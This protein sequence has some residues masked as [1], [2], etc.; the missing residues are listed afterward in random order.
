[1][2]LQ[3]C[4]VE[5]RRSIALSSQHERRQDMAGCEERQLH[6]A[7]CGGVV[8]SG[9]ASVHGQVAADRRRRAQR[10]Q[11]AQA[12]PCYPTCPPCSSGSPRCGG[13]GIGPRVLLL[14]LGPAVLEPDLDLGL[15]EGQGQGQVE[16]LAHR[17]VACGL[18]FVFQRHQLL[19]GEGSPGPAGLP[20]LGVRAGAFPL[21]LGALPC[22]GLTIAD[23]S[24]GASIGAL[25]VSAGVRVA[26]LSVSVARQSG[27]AL[28]A[29]V[30]P[31]R[32]LRVWS[33]R[34]VVVLLIWTSVYKTVL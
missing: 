19:V 11:A 32:T 1:M 7:P 5:G 29:A 30:G 21:G 33:P 8:V 16:A 10:T 18:E 4:A 23:L 3:V 2:A 31:I 34:A 22:V 15:G 28:L 6:Q 26:Q 27:A 9:V 20:R 17:Q 24:R 13:R 12:S 14:P 25:C